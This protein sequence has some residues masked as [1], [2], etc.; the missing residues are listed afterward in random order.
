MLWKNTLTGTTLGR[1]VYMTSWF[2]GKIHHGRKFR[3]PWFWGGSSCYIYNQAQIAI[4]ACCCSI[5]CSHL[6]SPGSLLEHGAIHS[7]KSLTH[8]YIQDMPSQAL[9]RLLIP[10]GDYRIY[11]DDIKHQ[12][13]HQHTAHLWSKSKDL[14]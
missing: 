14:K 7:S 2:K 1:E 9:I 3:A 13:S 6:Y 8:L 4:N 12:P 10:P 11:Q 5:L